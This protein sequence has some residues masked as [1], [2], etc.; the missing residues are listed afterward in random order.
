MRVMINTLKNRFFIVDGC[1]LKHKQSNIT[2]IIKILYQ[3]INI[4]TFHVKMYSL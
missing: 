4:I 2:L 1:S 3:H